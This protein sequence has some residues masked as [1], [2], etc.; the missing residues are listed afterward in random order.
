MDLVIYTAARDLSEAAVTSTTDLTPVS[1][2][3]A[4]VYGDTEPLNLTFTNDAAGTAPDWLGEAGHT[5]DLS[6]GEPDPQVGHRFTA[7]SDFTYD[8][9]AYTGSLYLGTPGLSNYLNGQY[10]RAGAT[11]LQVRHTD[12]DG[13][14]ET[15]ALL[16]VLVQSGPNAGTPPSDTPV[17]YAT[18]AEIQAA[19]TAASDSETAASASADASAASATAAS[20][21]ATLADQDRVAAQTAASAASISETNAA[22]SAQAASDSAGQADQDRIAAQAAASAASDSADDAA[23]SAASIEG[24]VA[25]AE[26]AATAAASSAS[27]A[28]DSADAASTSATNSANSATAA[29]N[30]ETNAANSA[31][32]AASSA[33]AAANAIA[34]QFKGGLAGASVPATSTLAGD[35]YRITSAG[36]SQ[37]KTWAIGDAAIYNGT[38]GSW[39]QLPGYFA[40][41]ESITLRSS[42]PRQ[43]ANY[44][45]SDG[46]TDGVRWT[47][48]TEGDVAGLPGTFVADI[49]RVPTSNPSSLAVFWGLGSD[50]A[51]ATAS[52]WLQRL[53]LG[54]SG[55]LTLIQYGA[56]TGDWRKLEWAGYRAAYSGRPGKV[57]VAYSEGN[58]TTAPTILID[59]VDKTS[60]F[61]AT[62][63]GTAP[64]WMPTNLDCTYFIGGD[65]WPS[66]LAPRVKYGLGAWT[67]A[68][69]LRHAQTGQEPDWWVGQ[70]GSAVPRFYDDFS[71][72]THWLPSYGVIG[73]YISGGV[74]SYSGSGN[75]TIS[76]TDAGNNLAIGELVVVEFTASATGTI[77]LEG[78]GG[79]QWLN[80][81]LVSEDVDVVAGLNRIYGTIK[82]KGYRNIGIRFLDASGAF[83]MDDIKIIRLGHIINPAINPGDR[84]VAD[85]GANNIT[86][87]LSSGLSIVGNNREHDDPIT[88]TVEHSGA[89][90]LQ[91]GGQNI[92]PTLRENAIESIIVTSDAAVAWSLGNASGGEQYVSQLAVTAA[93]QYVAPS[94]IVTY[95][96]TGGALWSKVDGA[97]DITISIKTR[98]R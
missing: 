20:N 16:R 71:T 41:Q 59:G 57:V 33:T 84:V 97:A 36:T 43:V 24:D 86:G 47:L 45:L 50:T 48:G 13:H 90:N 54:A 87:L 56:T 4:L 3:P 94:D 98:S 95:L 81:Y 6:L 25:A 85:L 49:P 64:N 75:V 31:T 37:S 42:T 17:D 26:A 55:E 78:N 89:G 51:P 7:T 82:A 66:G 38:S 53:T 73:D 76:S 28:S 93:E 91:F 19:A 96:L 14:T 10:A 22:N 30:S 40:G 23:A 68:E 72:T 9:P 39:T 88:L 79:V 69:A 32:A 2:F 27:D 1:E 58:S 67:A 44:L 77:R 60:E 74:L 18:Y 35:T 34:D 5:L 70:T 8:D 52:A 29:S 21:S 92:L 61:T 83:D 15:L 63:N 11:L 65:E 46:D 80:E 62:D 12:P